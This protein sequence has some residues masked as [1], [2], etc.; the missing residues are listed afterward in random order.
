MA[1]AVFS[2]ITLCPLASGGVG[3]GKLLQDVVSGIHS[4]DGSNPTWPGHG[5][6]RRLGGY[7]IGLPS[8]FSAALGLDEKSAIIF[9]CHQQPGHMVFS[10]FFGKG[11]YSAFAFSGRL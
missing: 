8:L 11:P 10:S 7:G 2:P 9:A 1:S 4:T 6:P 3:G 5:W